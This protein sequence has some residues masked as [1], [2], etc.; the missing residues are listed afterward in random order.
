MPTLFALREPGEAAKEAGITV[1]N[2]V[3]IDPGIDHLYAIKAI[4]EVHEKGGKVK[5]FYSLCGGLPGPGDSG[6]PLQ[7]KFSWSPRG[8]LL[9]QYDSATFL[10]D[11]KVVEIPNKDLMAETKPHHVLDRYSFLAYPNRDPVPF[12]EAYGTPEAHTVI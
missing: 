7:F 8:A 11:R 9:S 6:N 12:R 2:E 1:L 10:R 4:G 5:E 3:G